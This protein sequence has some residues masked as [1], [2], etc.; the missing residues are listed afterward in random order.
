MQAKFEHRFS[1]GVYLLNSFT[2]SHAIDNASGHLD[3][4]NGD[5]SRVN[6]ANLNGERGQSAYNQPI[7]KTLSVVWDL[8]FGSGRTLRQP[9]AAR[10]RHGARR[11]AAH[12]HQHRYERAALQSHL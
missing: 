9:H 12:C 4:P 6:L 10:Y 5:N 1:G 2:W 7:N 11:M 8:P 3:T